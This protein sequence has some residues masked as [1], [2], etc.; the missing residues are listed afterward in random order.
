[1]FDLYT[2]PVTNPLVAEVLA[3]SCAPVHEAHGA[4]YLHV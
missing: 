3:L 4:V 2:T 1:M